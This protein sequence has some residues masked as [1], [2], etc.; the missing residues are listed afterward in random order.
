[1]CRTH[2][3]NLFLLHTL[4]C[5]SVLPFFLFPPLLPVHAAVLICRYRKPGSSSDDSDCDI[6][7][8]LSSGPSPSP[9]PSPSHTREAAAHATLYVGKRSIQLHDCH[10]DGMF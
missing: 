2:F 9:S 3:S 5:A 1:M 10:N 6:S 4:L 8:W 7:P